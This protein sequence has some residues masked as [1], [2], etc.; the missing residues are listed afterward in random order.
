MCCRRIEPPGECQCVQ[1][2]EPLEGCMVFDFEN[3]AEP[4][5]EDPECE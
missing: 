4:E 5:G 2:D 1:A 3:A